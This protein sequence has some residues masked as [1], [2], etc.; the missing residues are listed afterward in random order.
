MST[1][2]NFTPVDLIDFD[3]AP[4]VWLKTDTLPQAH[5]PEPNESSVKYL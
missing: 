2:L 4:S 1:D 3:Y 5:Y